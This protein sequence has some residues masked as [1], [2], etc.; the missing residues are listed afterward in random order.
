MYSDSVKKSLEGK[1]WTE[2]GKYPVKWVVADPKMD[3]IYKAHMYDFDVTV[4]EDGKEEQKS[5]LYF[6]FMSAL[7]KKPF[8]SINSEAR[9]GYFMYQ[10]TLPASVHEMKSLNGQDPKAA[11]MIEMFKSAIETQESRSIMNKTLTHDTVF[12]ALRQVNFSSNAP[13]PRDVAF[14]TRLIIK[15]FTP[16]DSHTEEQKKAFHEFIRLNAHKLT[17][18]GNF[19]IGYLC[20]HPGILFKPKIEE[21]NWEEAAKE[22]VSKFYESCRL[23][24]HAWLDLP[25]TI[26]DDEDY[27]T[28]EINHISG[29]LRMVLLNHFN[30]IYNRYIRN[31]GKTVT[32]SYG[33]STDVTT[34]LTLRERI[35]FCID[36][37]ITPHF[38]KNR[39]GKLII[40][41]SILGE[42]QNMVLIQIR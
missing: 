27:E 15:N 17:V 41:H 30:D 5:A 26:D 8:T 10:D 16:N 34:D 40:F 35:D 4:A 31:L 12:P 42:L 20:A 6:P 1:Y 3:V 33:H 39:S 24:R 25:I 7:R 28:D 9:F 32:D 23:P 29:A 19:A 37:D 14:R 21:I 36:K 11:I 18:L 38:K 22:I 13:P 2:I